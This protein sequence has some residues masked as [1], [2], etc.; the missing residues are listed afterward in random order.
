VGDLAT[1]SI[2]EKQ[3]SMGF[4]GD[5]L[6]LLKKRQRGDSTVF[7]YRAIQPGNTTLIASPQN[8]PGDHCISCVTEHYFI[9]VV[10]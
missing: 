9:S 5:S 4:A 2:S 3:Y 10:P 7:V 6:T 8:L 1:L